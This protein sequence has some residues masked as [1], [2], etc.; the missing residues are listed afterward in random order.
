MVLVGI[1]SP[2]KT[3]YTPTSRFPTSPCVEELIP[4]EEAV[5]FSQLADN[6]RERHG[7]TPAEVAGAFNEEDLTEED[8]QLF[9][10]TQISE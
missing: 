5:T 8:Y 2:W 3:R 7:G 4:E 6:F 1:A 10:F 9:N